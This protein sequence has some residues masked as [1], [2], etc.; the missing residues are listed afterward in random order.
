MF[1]KF[2]LY[3]VVPFII[4]V[5]FQFLGYWGSKGLQFL[6]YENWHDFT[7]SAFDNKVPFLTWTIWIYI[8]AYPFW[9][10]F[11]IIFAYQGGKKDFYNY[12]FLYFI[13]VLFSA[14]IFV[15]IPTTI[16]RPE[17]P[18]GGLS[19]WATQLI[20]NSDVPINL[21]PSL[22]VS[23]SW[24]I[25]LSFRKTK[26]KQKYLIPIFILAVLI[27]IS[28]QTIKQHYIVDVI[29]SLIMAEGFG[30][31]IFK[32]NLGKYFENIFTKLNVKLKLDKEVSLIK[33]NKN[34]QN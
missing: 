14:L 21:F 3:S 19:N 15:L 28:T 8:I 9:Y 13:I 31:F 34:E 23:L 32:Y 20:F 29:L 27:T 18:V 30:Y 6:L 22:H 26:L 33:L 12:L 10:I 2:P 25:Y 5:L 1:K 7:I 4:I 24:I 17:V 16:T 11:P